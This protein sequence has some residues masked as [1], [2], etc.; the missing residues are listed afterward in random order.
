MTATEELIDKFSKLT[1]GEK[2]AFMKSVLPSFFGIV[3]KNPEKMMSEIM[4]MC[5]QMMKSCNMDMQ[6]MM[7]MMGMRGGPMGASKQ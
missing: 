3:A 5:R 7:R 4:P 6:G 1:D 2:L